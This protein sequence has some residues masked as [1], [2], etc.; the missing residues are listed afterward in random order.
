[1]KTLVNNQELFKAIA[2]G[3]EIQYCIGNNGEWKEYNINFFYGNIQYRIKP[4]K[5]KTWRWVMKNID[6]LLSVTSNHYKNQAHYDQ[7]FPF[8]DNRLIQLILET[9]KEL[10][11]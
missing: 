5:I 9:E 1:M 2:E 7:I 11:E 10:E 8:S 3:K 6:D 4:K